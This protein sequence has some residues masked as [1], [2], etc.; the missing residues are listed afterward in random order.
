MNIPIFHRNASKD[1]LFMF[2]SLTVMATLT[3]AT[4]PALAHAQEYTTPNP[5]I[6]QM[7]TDWAEYDQGCRGTYP[8]QGRDGFCGTRS[9]LSFA[10]QREGVCLGEKETGALFFRACKNESYTFEDPLAQ[11]RK[12][13]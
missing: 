6:N 2:K 13:F 11:V 3:F 10:L 5:V 12:D 1:V 8:D 7:M 9:Y 4:A